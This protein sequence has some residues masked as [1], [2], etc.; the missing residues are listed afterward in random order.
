MHKLCFRSNNQHNHLEM[1]NPLCTSMQYYHSTK[2]YKISDSK[3]FLLAHYQAVHQYTSLNKSS[4]ASVND[5]SI[6]FSK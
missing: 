5:A 2:V 4:P 1:G 3:T 6:Y